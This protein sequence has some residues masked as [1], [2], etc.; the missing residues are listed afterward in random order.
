MANYDYD[1]LIFRCDSAPLPELERGGGR[2]AQDLIYVSEGKTPFSNTGFICQNK[3]TNILIS[4]W[5]LK[6]TNLLWYKCIKNYTPRFST[7][8]H[9]LQGSF[10]STYEG[11]CELSERLETIFQDAFTLSDGYFFCG[12]KYDNSGHSALLGIRIAWD[13]LGSCLI[14]IPGSAF[15]FLHSTFSEFSD[16]VVMY[17]LLFDLLSDSP[18]IC[19]KFRPTRLDL[20]VDDYHRILSPS[21]CYQESLIGNFAGF[22]WQSIFD[23]SLGVYRQKAVEFFTKEYRDSDGVVYPADTVYFGSSSGQKR[24]CI[25]DKYCESNGLHNCYRFEARFKDDQA[26]SKFDFLR[27][28]LFSKNDRYFP[29][30]IAK[31]AFS[32][33]SFIDRK[34]GDRLS[35]MKILPFWQDC[36]NY[37]NG[38][39]K[40]SIGKVLKPF[41]NTLRWAFKQWS[42]TT[43][44]LFRTMTYPEF[45]FFF[46]ELHRSGEENLN[47]AHEALI[48]ALNDKGFNPIK[49]LQNYKND[50]H[51]GSYLYE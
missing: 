10:K 25:Y 13:D 33:I 43:A 24:L 32:I 1:D 21:R 19:Y 47:K 15:D 4:S 46:R 42:T 35:R 18:H 7:Q 16:L 17:Q 3:R 12:R 48:N 37:L 23:E 6:T 45:E 27:D 5:L 11:I 20:A 14:S 29:Q 38:V 39:I 40:L 50:E 22:R 36:L 9:W 26:K 49:W 44:I 51:I 8:I 34:S 41:D 2:I 30:A 31:L 28:I